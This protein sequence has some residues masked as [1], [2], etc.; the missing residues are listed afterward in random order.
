MRIYKFRINTENLKDEKDHELMDSRFSDLLGKVEDHLAVVYNDNPI[1][2]TYLYTDDQ[3]IVN[4]FFDILFDF[5]AFY[6]MKEITQDVL[7]DFK[8]FEQIDSIYDK[9]SSL[10]YKFL[11]DNIDTDFALDYIEKNGKEKFETD[12]LDFIPRF[13]DLI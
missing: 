8:Q 1:I 13:F 11:L 4:G 6:D 10:L 2:T 12:I 5:N 7:F 3:S 9:N